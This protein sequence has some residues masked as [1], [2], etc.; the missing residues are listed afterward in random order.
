MLYTPARK[1]L[2][3]EI[4]SCDDIEI[5]K[6]ICYEL[7]IIVEQNYSIGNLKSIINFVLLNNLQKTDKLFYNSKSMYHKSMYEPYSQRIESYTENKRKYEKEQREIQSY[8]DAHHERM[9]K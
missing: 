4:D 2:E 6:H 5:L 8:Y 1:E 7:D 3:I 9:Y